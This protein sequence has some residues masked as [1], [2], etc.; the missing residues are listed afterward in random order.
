LLSPTIDELGFLGVCRRSGGPRG[1]SP[2]L[3]SI[4]PACEADE[5]QQ[6]QKQVENVQVHADGQQ[7][8]LPFGHAAALGNAVQVVHQEAGE[9]HGRHSGNPDVQDRQLDEDTDDRRQDHADQPHHQDAA[10]AREVAFG[11]VPV[12]AR[13]DCHRRRGQ[14]RVQ[15]HPAEAPR[16]VQLEEQAQRQTFKGGEGVQQAKIER[17]LLAR[18]EQAKQGSE[19]ADDRDQERTRTQ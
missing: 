17:R 6:R 15:H 19:T 13:R 18:H 12:G 7:D 4:V 1:R 5:A 3:S 2:C 16:N 14:R 9:Q 10:H 8:G 11:G